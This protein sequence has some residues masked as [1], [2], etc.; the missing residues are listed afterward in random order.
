M[1][2]PA[3]GPLA[4]S[5]TRP[6]E[7]FQR[8]WYIVAVVL[9]GP[10][11]AVVGVWAGLLRSSLSEAQR[12]HAG[13]RDRSDRLA[14]EL[15]AAKEDL[16]SVESDLEVATEN[17][18]EL[19]GELE[20]RE[21]DVVAVE[22][23]FPVLVSEMVAVGPEGRYSVD[24]ELSECT[25]WSSCD[26]SDWDGELD[27]LTVTC[28]SSCMASGV[29][30]GRSGMLEFN[31]E[32]LTWVA[33]GVWDGA[34]CG[35]DASD[36]EWT[37]SLETVGVALEAQAFQADTLVGELRIVIGPTACTGATVVYEFTTTRR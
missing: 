28:A 20:E 31:E 34:S 11:L 8:R 6:P 37:V 4:G 12:D 18:A 17:V 26:P 10:A 32:S 30:S 13:Q 33:V 16:L 3:V 2:G 1:P 5:A 9:L 23:L 15:V 25:G 35:D 29:L 7:G 36:A 14:E 27:F 24:A 19:E 22:A 21:N